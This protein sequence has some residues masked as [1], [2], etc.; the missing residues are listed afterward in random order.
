MLGFWVDLE[1]LHVLGL[2]VL[3]GKLGHVQLDLASDFEFSFLDQVN[4]LDWLSL[5]VQQLV[6]NEIPLFEVV[7]QFDKVGLTVFGQE[8]N[9]F[10]EVY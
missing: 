4:V 5:L 10:K 8:W 2:L 7:V 3:L 9:A 6:S 1:E